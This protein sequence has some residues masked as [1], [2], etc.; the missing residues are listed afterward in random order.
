MTVHKIKQIGNE[1]WRITSSLL[2][3][4]LTL[5]KVR[6][7][8]NQYKFTKPEVKMAEYWQSSFLRVGIN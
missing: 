7:N 3:A 4:L 5:D 6:M 2:K 8:D 1:L